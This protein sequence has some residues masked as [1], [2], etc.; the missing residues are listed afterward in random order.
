MTPDQHLHFQNSTKMTI[1]ERARYP[2]PPQQWAPSQKERK[3]QKISEN[4][5]LLRETPAY[6]CES[7]KGSRDIT[8]WIK[9][10]LKI[11]SQGIAKIPPEIFH[12]LEDFSVL[13]YDHL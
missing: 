5:T 2:N 12:Y 8:W 6:H 3:T 4:Q 7:L 10:K 13:D 1:E 9:D 11:S